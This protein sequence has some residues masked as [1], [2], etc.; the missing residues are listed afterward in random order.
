MA[1]ACHLYRDRLSPA[2]IRGRD[3][4]LHAPR[5]EAGCDQLSANAVAHHGV[6]FAALPG[7]PSSDRG[8]RLLPDPDVNQTPELDDAEENRHQDERNRQH[9][10][11]RFLPTLP[12]LAGPR[13]DVWVS[14]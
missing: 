10:L 6:I 7:Y 1:V 3:V 4:D 8:G 5:I 13:H 14:R 11:K 2:N 9:R 12:L